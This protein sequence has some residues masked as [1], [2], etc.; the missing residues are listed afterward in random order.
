MLFGTAKRVKHAG[1][2]DLKMKGVVLQQVPSYRYLGVTHDSTLSFKMHLAGVTRTV[3]HKIY[4]LTRVRK[5]LTTRSALMVYKSMI[6]PY[7]D[8]ADIAYEKAPGVD[9]EK[10]Q[11]LQ[12]RALKVCLNV[13]KFEETEV[14]HRRA[15]IPLL[16][17]RRKAHLL[18]YMY[19]QK[20]LGL[21]L[22]VN[23]VNTR[24]AGAPKFVLPS[25]N[26][27]CYKGRIEY[28]G[29]KAWNSMPIE[30]RLIPSYKSFKAKIHKEL[31]D[32]VN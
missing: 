31:L 12:N 17:N 4:V 22:V 27:Q 10:I 24:S 20:E 30:Y 29:A 26:L 15:K 28:S 2:V 5:Y 9:L 18:S 7:F 14:V 21:N 6:M 32:T 19:K 16:S 1:K 25:P 8:Y 13:G 3:A 23:G 11:R